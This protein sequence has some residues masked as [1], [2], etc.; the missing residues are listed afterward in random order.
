MNEQKQPIDLIHLTELLR[1]TVIIRIVSIVDVASLSILELLEYNDFTQKEIRHAMSEGVIAVDSTTS[2]SQRH[3]AMISEGN[4]LISGDYYLYD[5]L[6]SKLRLTELGLYILDS[7]KGDS[8]KMESIKNLKNHFDIKWRE[9]VLGLGVTNN[10][11][12]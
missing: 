2:L 3:Y 7:I 5:F 10:F 1:D 8:L 11:F 12:I 4:N 9:Q 6:N